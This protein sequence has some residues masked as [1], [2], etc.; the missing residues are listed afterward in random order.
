[1]ESGTY[2]RLRYYIHGRSGPWVALG[3]ATGADHEG[4]AAQVEHLRH[5]ARLVLWDLPGHGASASDPGSLDLVELADE[6]AGLLR[7][8]AGPDAR[9]VLVGHSLSGYLVQHVALRHPRLAAGVVAMGCTSVTIRPRTRSMALLV[10]SAVLFSVCPPPVRRL[11]V[12]RVGYGSATARR[13]LRASAARTSSGAARAA[14]WSIIRALGDDPAA[15]F[16]CPLLVAHGQ[17]DRTGI[18]PDAARQ[19]AVAHGSGYVVVPAAGH[20]A[21]LDNPAFVNHTL[22]EFLDEAA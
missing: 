14:W 15:R 12:M 20:H 21:H 3:H 1:M 5:R 16:A 17:H 18:I 10:V 4:F 13:Y 19:W 6:V 22:A 9:V 2:G 11:L 8:L 7:H